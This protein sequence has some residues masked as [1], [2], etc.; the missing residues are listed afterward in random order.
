MRRNNASRHIQEI[1]DNLADKMKQ[2]HGLDV[3][4]VTDIV[5][6]CG[7]TEAFSATMFASDEVILFDSSFKT[8]DTCITMAEGV[9]VSFSEP[10]VS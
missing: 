5:I 8:Y 2:M 6:C 1:S 7:Q 3:D 10:F 9:P 4:P